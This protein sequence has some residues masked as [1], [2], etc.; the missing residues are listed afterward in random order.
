[1]KK[2]SVS[3]LSLTFLLSSSLASSANPLGGVVAAGSAAISR[4]G[5]G[6]LTINQASDRAVINWNS[7][8]IGAGE[9]TRFIQPGANSAALNRVTG[10]NVSQIYG[11]LQANGRVYVINPS[12]ILIGP[13][14]MVNT[15]SFVAS[16]LDVKDSTFLAG[17]TMRFA[18]SSSASVKNEGTINA[19]GGDVFLFAHTVDN[20]GSINAADGTVGLGAGSEILLRQSGTERISVLAGNINAPPTA[21]GVNNAGAVKA[22][23]AELK[24]AGGNIYALA[25]NNGGIVRADSIVNQGGRIMLKANGGNIQNSGTLDASGKT[26]GSVTLDGGHNSSSPATVTSSGTI[27]AKGSDGKG[28]TA[29][30]VGD[31]VGLF[32]AALVDVSGTTGGGTAL[33]G[34]DI[35]GS[36]PNTQNAEATFVSTDAQIKADALTLGSGGRVVVWSDEITRFSGYIS[37]QGAGLRGSGGFAEVSGKNTLNYQGFTD[38]RGG[39]RGSVGQL[40]LDPKNITVASGGTD[41]IAANDA[42]GENP[43]LSVTFSPASLVTALS[44]ADVTLEANNNIT[45]QNIVNS[46]ASS[47]DLTLRAGGS[48]DIQAALTLGGAFSATFND[49]GAI[50]ANRDPGAATFTSTAAIIAAGGISIQAGTLAAD[51]SGA[52]S[53]SLNTG[54][55][56]VTSLRS[57]LSGGTAGVSGGAITVLNNQATGKNITLTTINSAGDDNSG[58][59]AGKAGGN[60]GAAT[61]TASGNVALTSVNSSGGAGSGSSGNGGNGGAVA[62]AG[63]GTFAY[64]GTSTSSG[65]NG[66]G[67]AVGGNAGSFSIS[68]GTGNLTLGDQI[69]ATGGTG[70]TTDGNGGNIAIATANGSISV[71]NAGAGTD[72]DAGSAALALTAGGDNNLLTLNGSLS[73]LSGVTLTADRMTINADIT[74]TASSVELKTSTATRLITIGTDDVNALTGAAGTLGLTTTEIAHAKAGS[75]GLLKVGGASSG[76]LSVTAPL[77]I[78]STTAGTLSLQSGGTISQTAASIITVPN[79]ALRA[80]NAVTLIEL[81]PVTT[82][83]GSSVG[84]FQFNALGA[85]TVDS[86]TDPVGTL[87]GVSS[88]SAQVTL[89]AGAAGALALNNNVS[90]VGVTLTGKGV[91]QSG[92]ST[93]NGGNGDITVDANDGAIDLNGTLTTT[94]AS[95]TAVVLK[96]ATTAKLGNISAANGTVVLGQTTVGDNL[97]GAVSQNGITTINANTVVAN[98]GAGITLDHNNTIGT[99]GT[100]TLNGALNVNDIA[101]G[102][103]VNTVSGTAG[104][105][106]TI[107]TLGDL[108]INQNLSGSTVNLTAA[109]DNSKLSIVAPAI[110]TATAG[111]TL[112]GDQMDLKGTVSSA[113]NKVTLQT[114]SSG[115]AI[116]LGTDDVSGPTATTGTLGLTDAELDNVTA[117]TIKVGGSSSGNITVS[118]G[119]P[120]TPSTATTLSLETAGS[121]SQTAG[122]TIT[123]QNLAVR[124]GGPVTLNEN[125]TVNTI[126]ASVSGSGNAFAFR[127]DAA[128]PELAVGVVDGV[129]G[130]TTASGNVTLTADS[131]DIANPI[132]ATGARVRLQPFTAGRTVELGNGVNAARLNL[133]D[134]ELDQITASVLQIGPAGPIDVSAAITLASAKLPT[135]SLINNN[136]INGVGSISVQNLAINS[137]GPVT[138][139]GNVDT[140]AAVITGLGNTFQF[141][142]LDSLTVGTVDSVAGITTAGGG[143]ILSTGGQLTI[144]DGSGQDI[145]ALGGFSIVTLNVAAGGAV[146]NAGSSILGTVLTLR[147]AGTF[148]LNDPGNDVTVIAGLVNGAISYTDANAVQTGAGADSFG[149]LNGLSSGNNPITL[150]A[151]SISLPSLLSSGSAR[152]ILQPLTAGRLIDLGTQTA[153]KLSLDASDLANVTSGILQIGNS[154]AGAIDVS[155]TV[156][157]GANTLVLVNNGAISGAGSLVVPNLRINSAGPVTLAGANDVDN[158]AATVSGNGNGLTFNDTDDLALGTVDTVSGV[159]TLNGAVNLSAGGL[160]NVNNPINAGFGVVTLSASPAG[161]SVSGSGLITA[162]GLSVSANAGVGTIATPL[163]TAVANLEAQTATGG[164]FVNN[165][166]GGGALTVGGVSALNGIHVTTSGNIQL[167]N[168]GS[169]LI[170]GLNENVVAP[171][172]ITLSANGATAD[173]LTGGNQVAVSSTGGSLNLSAGRDL[174]LGDVIG[175]GPIGD[176]IGQTGI[177]LNAGR[178]IVIDGDTFVIANGGSV[179]AVAAR[180]FAMTHQ[181]FTAP[182]IQANGGSIFLEATT[183]TFTLDSS[184]GSV[185]S[186]GGSITINTPSALAVLINDSVNAGPSGTVTLNHNG[187]LTGS[188]LVTAGTLNLQGVGSVGTALGRLNTAAG[189]IVFSKA[190]GASFVNEQDAVN[191]AGT[192]PS[193]DL[194]AGGAIGQSG[195]LTISG[196]LALKTLNDSGAAITLDRVGD[197][198]NNTFGSVS[199]QVLKLDG[200]TPAAAD[201]VI[202]E[203]DGN[204]TVLAGVQTAGSLTVVSSGPITESAAILVSGTSSFDAGAA[205]N[206]TLDTQNNDFGT[207]RIV[208]GNNVAINDINGIDLGASAVSGNLAV[209][210]NGAITDSGNVAVVGT[211]TL[212][213][214]AGNNI[215]LDN[216][217]DF[218][219]T[220][221]ILTGNTVTLNDVNTLDLGASTVSGNLI[222]TANGPI[223]DSGDLTVT[224]TTTLAA[225]ANNI[226]LNNADDFGG[227]VT[228]LSGND[229]S[230][231][232]INDLTVG[233]AVGHDLATTAGGATAFNTL[234]VVH[235]LIAS[236]NGTIT[237]N[238]NVTVGGTTTLTAGSANDITLDNADDFGGAVTIVSGNNVTL[239]DVNNL[240]LGASTVSGNLNATAVGPITDSGNLTVVGTTTL[241]AGGNNITLDNADNFGG[242][243]T[244]LSGNDVTLNDINDLTV[245]GV[246]GHDLT[247]T[248]GGAIAFNALSVANNLNASGN[249][250]ITDNGNVAVG[251]TT[252]L[253]AGA[254]NITLNN[255]DDFGGAVTIVSGN[256]VTLNDV[257]SLTV[258]GTVSGNLATTAGSATAFNALTVG[259]NLNSSGNGTITDN[260]NVTVVG[261]TTLAAGAA[262]NITLDNADDFGGAVTVVSGND[263]FLNDVNALTVGGTVNGRLTTTAGSTTAF[264]TLDVGGD[265]TASGGGAITDNGNVRVGGAT[266]LAAGAANNITLDNA[267]DFVGAVTVV[268]GNDVRLNDVNSLTVG[269]TVSGG[270]TTTAG[271]ATAFNALT[272]AGNLNSSGNGTITDNG[273]VTVGGT[274]TLAA[275]AANNVTLDNADDFVGAV[276]VVSGNNVTLNDVNA[277]NLGASTISGNLTV[278]APQGITQSGAVTANG[279]GTLATF[280]VSTIGNVTLG[281]LN[282]DF[283]SVTVPVGNNITLSDANG[284]TMGAVHAAS[285]LSLNTTAGNIVQ[286]L[287]GSTVEAHTLTANLGGGLILGNDAI[288]Q[289]ANQ[290]ANKFV[291]IGALSHHGE[292][293]LYDSDAATYSAAGVANPVPGNAGATLGLTI[294]GPVS[295]SGETVIRTAGDLMLVGAAGATIVQSDNGSGNNII[296]SAENSGNFHNFLGS[297]GSHAVEVGLGSRFLIFSTDAARNF[298]TRFSAG[299][300]TFNGLGTAR[301]ASPG[302]ISDLPS[303][304][305]VNH[306]DPLLRQ[307][308]APEDGTQNGFVFF[309][310]QA[311]KQSDENAK[312]FLDLLNLTIFSGVDAAARADNLPPERPPTI[313]TST[314]HLYLEEQQEEERKKKKRKALEK[315]AVVEQS[316]PQSAPVWAA[317]LGGE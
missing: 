244:I 179:N 81:N 12:G 91:T 291:E 67:T 217:D 183:G 284:F 54:D 7:F 162:S 294:S 75:S 230:L 242:A 256:D 253:A 53:V 274:T 205:N 117:A 206:V 34:G 72:V 175:P 39:S 96:D 88:S 220:V 90:G 157:P 33:V 224:G 200:V 204:G 22:A 63:G 18:G 16:T 231:N 152:T 221:S 119:A 247:T 239:N 195:A 118:G 279:A 146:E 288:G 10:G 26:G 1:M 126:A 286:I 240:D 82:V 64:T 131:L 310:K 229:V 306:P 248:A 316:V 143:V 219:G 180:N 271:S 281:D 223:T 257:N 79:L 8:S 193:I 289:A 314:Y 273:N 198:V 133:S 159:S 60:G 254:N 36:N 164:I 259:G 95:A 210:A 163:S 93:V 74:A 65:G 78:A 124:A 85:L 134:T 255:A 35:H 142:D 105:N 297:D 70:S 115:R 202:H 317:S 304:T 251:G 301:G 246:V 127:N 21:V 296:L 130:I 111:A 269:G 203:N 147:G 166:N 87:N 292:L 116:T 50:A 228:I 29:K 266:T 102:L 278:T 112:T 299:K 185:Q 182:L 114:S 222:V 196:A 73:G 44:S 213:A 92:S 31:H 149:F 3:R 6:S 110:V 295:G 11:T 235:N 168:V 312:F 76:N 57:T 187:A 174:L 293:Y 156:T 120:I 66:A 267:D 194:V 129:T 101:G 58:S 23:S 136:T 250:T 283:T 84:A 103:N 108:A 199:A 236:G 141:T 227:A 69:S 161:A 150:T 24:A 184:G 169:I 25:I 122:S 13:S 280:N 17:V 71:A 307:N 125:N 43:T 303:P 265:L 98:T 181:A 282:N 302:F 148:S 285:T 226:T 52:T 137:T 264:N 176:I 56:T 106:V 135:L 212:A 30:I 290:P 272:V 171:G 41:P 61:V 154:T 167:N 128:A 68:A 28:G 315:K 49:A 15:H 252:T 145:S 132:T 191:I 47:H 2:I 225:G 151:D 287:D 83:A 100:F 215:T 233:G 189:N 249:G 243:V 245:G 178:D 208:S 276:S 241:A 218:G 177:A 144:G 123:V 309:N 160:L 140:L 155:A 113:G 121:I 42:F 173:L 308:G 40:L 261:T 263:V 48:I 139:S 311:F 300:L 186:L 192:A 170:N 237:D 258:G 107:S 153:G 14:G 45:F 165:N 62:L 80:G 158:L 207:V 305:F 260:G 109:G 19:L 275:G 9:I 232:D 4:N 201:V 37:A 97:S 214:G 188:G 211:T 268:S 55:I 38:L 89:N 262:N 59:G 238:G 197:T 5:P 46:A 298:G 51:S 172:N 77:A 20:A 277:I 27:A 104:Q 270:L 32:D 216:A 234:S 313:W 138:L 209:T 190:A 99:L 86:I 94:S